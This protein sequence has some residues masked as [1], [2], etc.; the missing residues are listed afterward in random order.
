MRGFDRD[1][2]RSLATGAAAGKVVLGEVL[3]GE[4]P[5][6]RP[7]SGSLSVSRTIS[8]PLNIYS[9]PDDVVRKMPLTFPST[10]SDALDGAGTGVARAQYRASVGGR[11]QRDACRLPR[12]ERSAEYADSEFRGWRQRCSDV[13]IRRSACLCVERNNRIFSGAN[14]PA[15][16]LSSGPC[17]TRKI[18]SLRPS[19][20]RPGSMARARRAARCRRR[21]RSLRNSS[22]VR[23]P[24][25]IFMRP[26]STILWPGTPWSNLAGSRR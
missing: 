21:S 25:S 9:D 18:A 10:E 11:R 16:L 19:V 15:R 20:L 2:L 23:S 1:F 17:S 6:R 7:D 13:F 4:Q 12:S 8:G 22:A 5:S 3:R 14:S 26:Q 24:A